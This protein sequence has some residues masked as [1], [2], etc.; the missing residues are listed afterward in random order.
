MRVASL[1]ARLST[2]PRPLVVD[3][4]PS[5]SLPDVATSEI[6][7]ERAFDDVLD[8]LEAA[9]PDAHTGRS[10]V[11]EGHPAY[12][13]RVLRLVLG[14]GVCPVAVTGWLLN[15]PA[16]YWVLETASEG[17]TSGIAGNALGGHPLVL[18]EARAANAEVARFS[19][20]RHICDA[21]DDDSHG[22]HVFLARWR[23]ALEAH[24]A[25][26]SL[27]MDVSYPP[28]RDAVGL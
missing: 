13:T 16:V 14:A 10:S 4:R 25:P 3:A 22:W 5:L 18:Y 20:P 27:E 24:V 26:H 11:S 28:T 9:L 23:T 2:Q 12:Q 8:A 15:Y 21:E 1:L 19:L 7:A 6:Q 17:G